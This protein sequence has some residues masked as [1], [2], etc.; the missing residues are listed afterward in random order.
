MSF[1]FFYYFYY[2][3]FYFRFLVSFLVIANV[4]LGDTGIRLI[5]VTVMK[6]CCRSGRCWM[7]AGDISRVPPLSSPLAVQLQLLCLGVV[8]FSWPTGRFWRWR[9]RFLSF[10][11]R[12]VI[13]LWLITL[14]ISW[15]LPLYIWYLTFLWNSDGHLTGFLEELEANVSLLTAPGKFIFAFGELLL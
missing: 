4:E 9:R 5:S 2:T 3:Y 8:E 14:A 11:R 12:C 15:H 1:T 6:G 13:G 7:T 10:G